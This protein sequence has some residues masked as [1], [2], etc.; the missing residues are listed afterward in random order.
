MNSVNITRF[1]RFVRYNSTC[2]ARFPPNPQHIDQATHVEHIH[3]RNLTK[4]QDASA[5][6]NA[7]VNE[8][9]NFK[10]KQKNSRII[11]HLRPTILTFEMDSVY[12]GGKRE[13]DTKKATRLL[14]DGAGRTMNG[15]PY[16]QTD[17]GG[18][19]T[20]HGPGQLVAYFIWDLRLWKNLT[21]R[22]FVNFIE[23]CSKL[24]IEKTGVPNVCTTK[25]TGVWV[26]SNNQLQKISSI[27]LNLKRNVTSHGLSINLKPELN[28]LNHTGFALCGLEGYKQTSIV[29]E[30]G[31]NDLTVEELGDTLC[32]VVRQRMNGY[33]MNG[34]QGDQIELFVNKTVYD[35][36]SDFDISILE[37]KV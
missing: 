30:V 1:S 13:K 15:V 20:Y 10:I 9:L 11:Y 12:T 7:I 14:L 35:H 5:V 8:H 18:Q 16:V 25:D 32:E 2:G 36:T 28:Y 34:L 24:A 33:M 21:S 37:C 27:G 23:Q 31:D 4:Y 17:R 29:N 6:Q 3:F 26:K 19:V 22:C